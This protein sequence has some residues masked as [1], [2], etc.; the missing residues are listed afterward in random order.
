MKHIVVVGATSAIA[1]ECLRIWAQTGPCYFS[2]L[3]RDAGRIQR[4]AD[5]LKA[6]SSESRVSILEVDFLNPQS[7]QE[8]ID[9]LSQDRRIDI[10]LI[11]HGSLPEQKDC[12]DNLQICVDELSINAVSPALFAEAIVAKMAEVN[13]GSLTLIGSVAG[14]RGRKSNYT[15]G[16]AKALVDKYAQGLQH[17]FAKT[18]IHISLI[19]PG[20]TKTPMT[21]HLV[22][23][24]TNLAK[25]ED[26]ASM[27]VRAIR[28]KKQVV[29]APRKWRVIMFIIR[30][31]PSS[32]F[33]KLDI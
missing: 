7:I 27:I 18:Q 32:I 31:L 1:H 9:T 33:N 6:R 5:D 12:Q 17:R 11:A 30:C 16:S 25:A 15:Y 28:K 4:V 3:G 23:N 29:Y 8:S 13:Y 20:P 26:I 21:S 19:K 10:A 24:G 22:E 2:L 14:D